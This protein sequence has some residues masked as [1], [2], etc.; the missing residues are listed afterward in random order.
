MTSSSELWFVM[1]L[2][3][4]YN[5]T[6]AVNGGVVTFVE[7]VVDGISRAFVFDGRYRSW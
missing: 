3:T 6:I 4:R 1:T 7:I 5:K 2:F